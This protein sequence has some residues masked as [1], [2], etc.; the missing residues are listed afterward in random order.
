MTA[1]R[2]LALFDFDG[3]ITTRDTM[4]AF[5]VHCHGQVRTLLG[6]LWLSPMLALYSAKLIPNHRAKA[7]LLRHFFGGVPKAQLEA[8]AA[9]F[10]DQIDGWV[11]PAA[12]ERL[13]WHLDRG[14][15][16][17][18][19]SASLDLWLTP[20]TTREHLKLVCTRG[21][22]EAGCFTGELD[23]DNVH[24]PEKVRRILELLDP[25]GYARIYAYGDSSGDTEML[26]LAHEPLYKPFRS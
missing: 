18:V 3:T 20:W 15:D 11:R 21:R 25:K 14:H 16:V 22:F 24:G 5:V 17:F 23:G 12:R 9:T 19:V 4:L 2:S 6:L 7:I 10:A 13:R 8:W 26:A 1:H